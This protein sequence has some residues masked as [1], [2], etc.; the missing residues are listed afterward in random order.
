MKPSFLKY[1]NTAPLALRKRTLKKT[2]ASMDFA[3]HA[4]DPIA[5]ADLAPFAK[6]PWAE[7]PTLSSLFTREYLDSESNVIVAG[8]RRSM[9]QMNEIL[10][11]YYL[12]GED[13]MA[14]RASMQWLGV[15]LVINKCASPE[16]AARPY[17][18][19]NTATQKHDDCKDKDEFM[20]IL[21]AACRTP[22]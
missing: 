17:K 2:E 16:M 8:V 15:K 7:H 1:L 5:T 9:S 18:K 13:A 4:P 14:N 20:R 10:P 22:L 6:V 19:F 12:G 3:P 11:G 21:D